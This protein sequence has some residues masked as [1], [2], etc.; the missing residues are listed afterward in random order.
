MELTGERLIPAPIASTWEALNDTEVLRSCI[1]GCESLERVEPDVMMAVLAARVGP[2]SARFKGTVKLSDVQAPNRYVLSFEGQGGIAGFGRGSADVLLT[3]RGDHTLLRYS[4][5]AQVGGRL[6][7]V[8]SRLINAAASKITEDF[9]SAFEARLGP[10]GGDATAD[11]IDAGHKSGE[12]KTLRLIADTSAARTADLASVLEAGTRPKRI[13]Q[14]DIRDEVKV[15]PSREKHSAKPRRIDAGT[16]VKLVGEQLIPAPILPTFN[17]LTDHEVL[18]A[19]IPGCQ[20]LDRVRLDTLAVVLAPLGPLGMRFG[21]TLRISNV[22]MP[23][24]YTVSF[25]GQRGTTGSATVSLIDE[26]S[27][28]RVR[29]ELHAEVRGYVAKAGSRVIEAIALRIGKAFFSAIEAQLRASVERMA[30]ERSDVPGTHRSP[31][32]KKL[33]ALMALSAA[34]VTAFAP[35]VH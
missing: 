32:A 15:E 12:P 27:R 8:G 28:T 33:W 19:C 24:R 17:A 9:F 23:T 21:S 18:K 13:E 34:A 20:S 22:H 25:V 16:A 2:V 31:D 35:W 11:D 7:Q 1:A 6:A 3:E 5:R 4:S 30:E 10:A 14:K 29:Y 26:G